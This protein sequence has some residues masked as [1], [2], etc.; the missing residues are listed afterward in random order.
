MTLGKRECQ[1]EIGRGFIMSDWHRPP[2]K[3]KELGCQ[4]FSYTLKPKS[5]KLTYRKLGMT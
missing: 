1:G 5:I 2:T 4:L 3:F